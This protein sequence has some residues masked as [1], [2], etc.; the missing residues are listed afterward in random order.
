MRMKWKHALCIGMACAMIAGSFP[1]YALTDPTEAE[2]EVIPPGQLTLEDLKELN[3]G[4]GDVFTHNGRVTFV[5]GTCTP[6]PVKDG[7]DAAKVVDSMKW[8]I[9]ADSGNEF[10]LWREVFDPLGNIYYIFQQ[11]YHDTTVL[12]GAV[13]VITDA[14][15]NMTAL[16]C[17]VESKMPDVDTTKGITAVEA[18]KIAAD[19]QY[20]SEGILPE[21]FH[22][23]TGKVILPSVL[24]FSME[25]E[26]DSE[27]FA[28]VVYTDNPAEK[29]RRGSDLPYLAHYVS[30]SGEYLYSIPAIVPDDEAGRSG[31]DSGYL[32]EFMEPAEY[33]GYVDLSDGSEKEIS[34]TV[35]RDRRTGMYYLGNLERR[36]AV[37]QCYDF[38][39][40]DGQIVLE[41]SPDNLEWDQVGLLSLYNYCRAYDYYKE[42]GWIGGDGLE[43]PI[44]ILNHF[45][46]DHMNQINNACYVGKI[47][48]M[49]CFAASNANDLSQCLDVIAHEFT[50]C[51]THSLMTYNSYANDYGAINEAFSDIQGKNCQMMYGDTDT[52][53]W[54]VGSTSLTP[55]RSM[56][57]PHD[58]SQPE[59]TW[60]LYYTANAANPSTS[61][62][63]GGVH[64]NSSL[65]NQISYFLIN[66]GGMSLEDARLF[67]FLT[68]CAAVPQTDYVQLAE[69]L[70]W[71]LKTAG[72]EQYE[73]TL[74]HALEATRLSSKDLPKVMDSD[75]AMLRLSLPSTEAF[76]AGNWMM[77]VNSVNVE[78]LLGNVSS[79]ISS[80]LNEDY[81]FLPGSVQDLIRDGQEA[82]AQILSKVDEEGGL[83]LYL[84]NRIPDLA[85]SILETVPR[86]ET[87]ESAAAPEDPERYG[88]EEADAIVREFRTWL[89]DEISKV[90]FSSHGFAGQD[91]NTLN[92]V[93]R[94]G[95]C[96]PML[97]HITLKN[98]SQTPDQ[99]VMAFYLNGKWY[100]LD[101]QAI[102]DPDLSKEE[103]DA[104]LQPLMQELTE[105]LLS[106]LAQIQS[107]EDL[108]DLISVNVKG[109]EIVELSGE[110]LEQITIP[111]PTP[112]EEKSFGT[113]EPGR[114]S[115]P[116]QETE[117]DT[118]ADAEAAGTGAVTKADAEADTEAGTEADTLIQSEEEL[119][120]EAA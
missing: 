47:Q 50:H 107:P 35:M 70:P 52:D 32:F 4:K 66:D 114:K 118:E 11:M 31:Y 106:G 1:A 20:K 33:T 83:F 79:V 22:Q 68:E 100:G 108:Q 65:L 116:K 96:I 103:L 64:S 78:N 85:G 92:M 81:S 84:L 2:T 6:D 54:V 21:I 19:T 38:L 7:E 16:S 71:V 43:T 40:N 105:D 112:S 62:D 80:L 13:K 110:G 48:G 113:L 111:E 119:P 58:F 115:R 74:D 94:P 25:N 36:I 67:W 53:N 23:Y 98:G 72:M 29:A 27:R 3:H 117:A 61:N 55:I 46:D 57:D 51:V 39:Y 28:W 26:D 5:D 95:R 30:M 10:L 120:G 87:E 93:V 69:L 75:R 104:I 34:V 41:Y 9:G 24:K 37:A 49:Q 82:A 15:G 44:L 101:A 56:S 109:G 73:E 60:D 59:Y 91:G 45:C 77:M 42:I 17:S 8:L 97:Q 99:M 63:H 102:L 76:D 89:R 18:E 86:A 88:K 90:L 12:G 14:G